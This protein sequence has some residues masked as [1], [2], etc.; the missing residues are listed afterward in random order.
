MQRIAH[1]NAP[2]VSLGDTTF[3]AHGADAAATE[4]D[5]A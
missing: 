1:H 4:D 2:R 3:I 5:A